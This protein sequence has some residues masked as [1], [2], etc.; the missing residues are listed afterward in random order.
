MYSHINTPN[1]LNEKL[2]DVY[3]IIVSNPPYIGTSEEEEIPLSVKNF[4]PK[5]ALFAPP[6]SVLAFYEKIAEDC[7]NHLS[8]KGMIFL[9]INQKL[10]QQTLNLFKKTLSKSEILKDLSGNE[11]FIIGNK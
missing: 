9:E 5:I 10:G 11:R 2:D 3:D 8:E 1:Y 4:E 7:K 6:E